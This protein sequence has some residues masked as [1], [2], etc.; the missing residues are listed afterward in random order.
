MKVVYKLICFCLV[1]TL[2]SCTKGSQ[3]YHQMVSLKD[4][5]ESPKSYIEQRV[6]FVGYAYFH[7]HTPSTA[8][9]IDKKS[10]SEP[11]TDSVVYLATDSLEENEELKACS[12]NRVMVF[13]VFRP[14]SDI[15]LILDVDKGVKVI[16]EQGEVKEFCYKP[17]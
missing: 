5:I 13:G 3:D 7:E 12:G 17:E 10:S 4:L 14:H 16:N 2:F 8:V 15:G 1:T 6:E 9:Y 11:F